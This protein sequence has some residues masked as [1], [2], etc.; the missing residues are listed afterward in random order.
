VAADEPLEGKCSDGDG[1]GE[2]DK[3]DTSPSVRD[4][5]YGRPIDDVRRIR[6]NDESSASD[7]TLAVRSS[8]DAED[9]RSG[10]CGESDDSLGGVCD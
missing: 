1:E 8:I 9:D 10:L 2:E 5:G 7:E 3:S 6:E 4:G